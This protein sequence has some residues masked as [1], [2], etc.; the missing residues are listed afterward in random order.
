MDELSKAG[1]VFADFPKEFLKFT[2]LFDA[3]LEPA[4]TLLG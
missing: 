3:G 1:D 2:A 4:Q